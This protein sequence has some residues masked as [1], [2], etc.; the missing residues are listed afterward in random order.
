MPSLATRALQTVAALG[1][2][3]QRWT[4]AAV[5]RAEV[6]ALALRPARYSP[7]RR[8]DRIVDISVRAVDGWPVYDLNPKREPARRAALYLHGGG[9]I[10]EIRPQHWTLAA[11]LASATATCFTVPIYPLAPSG[12]AA[13]VLPVVEELAAGVIARNG[14]ERAVLMGDSAG[15]GIVL[16]TAQSLRDRGLV[17]AQTV[18]VS[19][20]LD[21]SLAD[22]SVRRGTTGPVLPGLRVAGDLYRGELD[23]QDPRVSPIYGDLAGLGPIAIFTGTRD[24]VHGDSVRLATRARQAG[25]SVAYHEASGLMHDYPLYPLPESRQA[26]A[27]IRTLISGLAG[28]SPLPG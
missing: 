1:G 26:R 3:D 17:A 28:I 7:P 10:N 20:W 13:A 5:T 14:A 8:L 25:V 6:A 11:G 15:A 2:W 16:A 21:L 12:T 9:F 23:L 18:L 27:Q 22:P 4:D 24:R 19:P